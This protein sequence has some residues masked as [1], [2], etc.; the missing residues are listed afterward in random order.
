MGSLV[1]ITGNEADAKDVTQEVFSYFFSR[2]PGFELRA[3]LKTFLYPVVRNKSLDLIRKRKPQAVLDDHLELEAH[4]HRDE[5][6]ERSALTTLVSD[7]P[8]FQREV[9]ILRF[10]DGMQLDE[11]ANELNIPKGTV[12]SRL[13]NALETL[14]KKS[15]VP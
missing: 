11:I 14:R 10:V 8:D 13:H 7:L 4:P 2:F 6:Q 5:E 1:K 9:V 3:Q 15:N 12:K